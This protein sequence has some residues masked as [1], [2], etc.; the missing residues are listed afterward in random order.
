MAPIYEFAIRFI[1]VKDLSKVNTKICDN[2]RK[3]FDQYL[4]DAKAN[5]LRKLREARFRPVS[6]RGY[7]VSGLK[8]PTDCD[9]ITFGN[10]ASYNMGA[11]AYTIDFHYKNEVRYCGR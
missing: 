6:K 7:K 11:V 8:I 10:D 3:N 4:I 9:V 2:T 5:R 1:T